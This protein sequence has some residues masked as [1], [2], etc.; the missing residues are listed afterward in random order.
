MIAVG[1]SSRPALTR[2]RRAYGRHREREGRGP[3]EREALLALPFLEEG[4]FAAEWAVRARS[5]RAFVKRVLEPLEARRREERLRVLDL[6]AG[7]GWL[8]YRMVER[9]HR[10]L[11]LDLRVDAVDGLSAAEP[12]R[13]HLPRMFGRVAGSFDALPL[14][15]GIADAAVFNA[16]LHYATDLERVLGE[17]V[18]VVRPGGRVAV[19]DSP[20]YRDDRDGEAMVE[21]K[22]ASAQTVFGDLAGDLTAL[23][24]VEYLT[25]DRLAGASR[26]PGLPWRR[27]RV[28]YPLWYELRPLR[29]LLARR[30]SPSRFDVWW[31]EVP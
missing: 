18:R 30:R 28:R 20:F 13:D 11:A 1:A 9:G 14:P 3:L 29:A 19:L 24:S 12:Y 6:G 27:V 5:F 16:S 26:R 15:D 31:T 23:D 7:N 10:A 4:P 22:R 2:F 21:E 25:A 8:C 17:A